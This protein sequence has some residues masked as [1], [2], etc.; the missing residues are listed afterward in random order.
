M[1]VVDWLKGILLGSFV[2]KSHRRVLDFFLLVSNFGAIH[3]F[4][5]GLVGSRVEMAPSFVKLTYSVMRYH[6]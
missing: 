3:T 5:D 1:K 6:Q 4:L 2:G